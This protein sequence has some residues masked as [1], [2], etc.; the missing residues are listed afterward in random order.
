MSFTRKWSNGMGKNRTTWFA[1][2]YK[3]GEEAHILELFNFMFKESRS[4]DHWYWKFRDNPAGSAIIYV[5]EADGKIVGHYGIVPLRI[6]VGEEYITGAQSMDTMTHP[7]YRRQGIFVKLANETYRA[8]EESGIYVT[9]GFPSKASYPVYVREL[10][11][12]D[13]G[14]VPR[15]VK[16]LDLDPILKKHTRNTI[17][18]KA[19][20]IFVNL[21]LKMM[22][23]AKRIPNQTGI[24]L[25]MVSSLDER[26]DEFWQKAS[27]DFRILVVRDK[28]YLNWRYLN[29]P[30]GGY[31]IYL[32]ESG[33]SILG[34]IVLKVVDGEVRIGYIVDILTMCE[35]TSVDQALV[36]K[37]IEH[38]RREKVNIIYCYI[39]DERY[40]GILKKSGFR[41]RSSELV[42]G[43]RINS[44]GLSETF[45]SDLKNWHITFGD[46][47][48]I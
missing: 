20:R 34:F 11:R 10:G 3:T 41:P 13:L 33:D 24:K 16:L 5:A 25:S 21:A 31:V 30:D 1:R 19:S 38:F 32:A 44:P 12:V 22:F 47:D 15:M 8:A 9:Y 6:K 17:L 45:L 42:L 36:S 18:F 27:A 2:R 35:Q 4:L 43:V 28:K 26:I 14:L 46:T 29:N 48:G 7:D 39:L 37:A 40:Y 23:K